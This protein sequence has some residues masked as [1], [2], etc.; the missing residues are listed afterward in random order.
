MQL[1]S[2][3]LDVVGPVFLVALVGYVWTA[4]GAPFDPK[5]VSLIVTGVGTPCLVVDSLANSGLKVSALAAMGL[6][7]VIS[8]AASLAGGYAVARVMRQPPVVYTPALA[9]PNT[10]NM[11][12]PLGMFAFGDR[13]LALAIGYYAV[14]SLLQFTIGQ[15]IA[16]RT[17]DPRALA[18]MPLIWAV[19]AGLALAL[20]G[21]SL[22]SIAARALHILG[23]L[24]VPLML[25]SLGHSLARLRL[26]SLKRGLIFSC[27]RL[28]GGFAIGWAVSTAL[29]LEGL[30][31]GVVVVQSS[32][33]SAVY[34]Y[35]FAERFNNQPEEVAGIVVLS[36]LLSVAILPFFLATVM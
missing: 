33:P 28:F 24:M 35:M 31:R 30:E 23:G 9:F 1:L 4:R 7:S 32:M 10:G 12:L 36:T 29:G 15:S 11:G 5:F 21:A 22:P 2:I 8:H 19:A 6:A 20:T 16:A 26:A 34:N 14:A 25:L 27:V 3:L 17:F 13:G 18:R